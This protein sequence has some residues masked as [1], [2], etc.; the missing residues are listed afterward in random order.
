MSLLT[1]GYYP[2]TYWAEDYWNDDYWLDYG[3]AGTPSPLSISISKS[4]EYGI[5]LSK[6]H[7]YSITISHT[8]GGS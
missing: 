1:A 8:G 7:E 4:H 6:S 3:T 2:P 5:T